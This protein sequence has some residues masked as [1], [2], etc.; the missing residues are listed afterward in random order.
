MLRV[1]LLFEIVWAFVLGPIIVVVF[2]LDEDWMMLDFGRFLFYDNL[3]FFVEMM[4]VLRHFDDLRT[5][6]GFDLLRHVDPVMYT[7]N[8]CILNKEIAREERV[9]LFVPTCVVNS[10]FIVHTIIM[11]LRYRPGSYLNMIKKNFLRGKLRCVCYTTL[12]Q[13]PWVELNESFWF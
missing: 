11:T 7:E 10:I 4:M 6:D 5:V 3:L 9:I 8:Y 12:N 1:P 2:L 13:I